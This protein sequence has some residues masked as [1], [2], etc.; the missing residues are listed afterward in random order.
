MG[1]H[2]LVQCQLYT[3]VRS[4][5]TARITTDPLISVQYFWSL[6]FIFKLS[7]SFW[8][9]FKTTFLTQEMN[10]KKSHRKIFNF[11]WSKKYFEK[12]SGFFWKFFKHRKIENQKCVEIFLGLF[13]EF[14]ILNV[15]SKKNIFFSKIFFDH[16]KLKNFDEIFLSSSPVLGRSF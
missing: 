6:I 7:E 9:H 12:K 4:K 5:V 16:K 8:N 3:I 10:L 15:F 2:Q 1:R 13:S 11:L 14:W